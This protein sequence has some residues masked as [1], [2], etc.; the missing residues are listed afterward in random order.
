[1]EI[2]WFILVDTWKACVT[3]NPY[4]A[5]AAPL[6]MSRLCS[7]IRQ[8]Y[9]LVRLSSTLST[10]RT[11]I[12]VQFFNHTRHYRLARDREGFDGLFLLRLQGRR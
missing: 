3:L 8:K 5:L 1:M 10:C 7:G 11:N 6:I 9:T 2:H 12:S 4:C